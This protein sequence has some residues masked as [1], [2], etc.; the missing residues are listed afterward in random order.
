MQLGVMFLAVLWRK[1]NK[2]L[3]KKLLV[4]Q[5]QTHVLDVRHVGMVLHRNKEQNNT[6]QELYAGGGRDTHVQED[7]VQHSVRHQVQ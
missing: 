2:L 4:V 3:I 6:F 5:L 7:A 1:Y